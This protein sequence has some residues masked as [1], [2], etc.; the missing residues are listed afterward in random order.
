MELGD[1]VHGMNFFTL[2]F[3]AVEEVYVSAL[4]DP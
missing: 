3:W 2:D 4:D 1:I